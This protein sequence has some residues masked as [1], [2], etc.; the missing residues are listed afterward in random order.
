MSSPDVI[1]GI[2]KLFFGGIAAFLSILLWSRTREGAFVCLVA[3][4]LL[5][6]AAFVLDLLRRFG[7][8]FT[9]DI[10]FPQ[11]EVPLVPLL[12]I[13]ISGLFFILSLILLLLKTR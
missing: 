2:V 12:F 11:T 4:V 13:V 5:G 1:L 6:Y 8:D 9:S 7:I 10:F 3:S